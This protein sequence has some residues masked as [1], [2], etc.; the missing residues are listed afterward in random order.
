MAMMTVSTSPALVWRIN[1]SS[2]SLAVF[3]W[4]RDCP[5]VRSARALVDRSRVVVPV[6]AMSNP[7]WLLE[8]DEDVLDFGVELQRMHPQFAADAAALV[9]AEGRFLMHAPAA[10]DAEHPRLDPPG[11]PQRAADVT[12]PDRPGRAVGG[13]VDQPRDLV[14]IGEGNDGEHGAEIFLLR[15]PHV[16]LGVVEHG[17]LEE[18]AGRQV[19]TRRRPTRQQACAFLP[20]ELDVLLHPRTLLHGDQGTDVRAG[21]ERIAEVQVAGAGRDP[22]VELV[23]DRAMDKGAAARAA[24]LARIAKDAVD[25]GRRRLLEV[26]VRKDDVGRFP[27]ELERHPRDVGRRQ[28]EDADAR[29]RL[30][31]KGDLVDTRMARERAARAAAWTGDHVEHALREAGLECDAPQFQRGERRVAR[32]LQDGGVA[33]RQGG[34]HLPG[35]DRQREIPGDDQR[36]HADRLAQREVESGRGDW[37]GLAEDPRGG[38]GVVLEALRG[39]QYLV[40]GVADRLAGVARLQRG[41]LVELRPDQLRD[42]VEHLRPDAGGRSTPGSPL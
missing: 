35:G 30:A 9:A 34:R 4:R 21:V 23:R 37:N 6:R 1:P 10:V 42:A 22:L 25:G 29:R 2:V 18:A 36:D 15:D 17:R 19:A 31:S 5:L 41:Q 39:A 14:L 26:R 16:I 7:S 28:L 33:R 32:R 38:A 24:V 3:S 20:P 40:A 13:V 27:S 11:D 8:T 12:R